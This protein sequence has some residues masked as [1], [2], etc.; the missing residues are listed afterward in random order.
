MADAVPS[1]VSV[2]GLLLTLFHLLL[3]GSQCGD[4]TEGGLLHIALHLL[5][6]LLGGFGLGVFAGGLHLL[7]GTHV[8]NT[9]G[10]GA[11]AQIH[12][13]HRKGLAHEGLLAI[14]FHHL[15]V[16]GGSLGAVGEGEGGVLVT[17]NAHSSVYHGAH[18]VLGLELVPRVGSEL[19]VAQG[20]LVAVLVEVQDDNVNHV[21]ALHHLCGMLDLVPTEVGDVDKTFHAVF[22]LCEH[23]EVGDVTDGSLV[24]G[25]YRIFLADA[26]PRVGGELLDAQGH[27]AG[28][29]VQGEDNGLYFVAHLQEFLSAVQTGA[30]AHFAHVYQ[31]FHAGFHLYEGEPPTGEE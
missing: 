15:A 16:E 1:K 12:N 21:A 8:G 3:Q 27:L 13:L 22:Q 24:L 18:R 4:V 14:F 28:L 31:A 5:D 9:D 30:P 20:Q 26:L 11:A 7:I 2:N 10:A 25:T 23:T 17:G 29:A 6:G 19:L